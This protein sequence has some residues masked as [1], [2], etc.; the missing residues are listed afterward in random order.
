MTDRTVRMLREL[1]ARAQVKFEKL[2]TNLDNELG[3]DQY[4]VFEG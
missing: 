3:D 4:I 1:D 2:F